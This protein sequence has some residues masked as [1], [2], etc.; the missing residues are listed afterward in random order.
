MR[1]LLRHRPRTVATIA[2][3]LTLLATPAAARAAA[4]SVTPGLPERGA[5]VTVAASGFEAHGRGIAQLAGARTRR[6]RV[7]ARGRATI[8]LYLRRATRTGS[9]RLRVRTSNKSVTTT[10]TVRA[11]RAAPSRLA[12]L[13]NGRRALLRPTSGRAGEPLELRITGHP[14]RAMLNVRLATT[15]LARRR[16]SSRGAL[17]VRAATPPVAP[18]AHRITI[19]SGRSTI[20]LPYRVRAS[21]PAPP[22]PPALPAPPPAPD[23][24]IAAAGDIACSPNDPDFAGGAGTSA[25]CRQR[26]TSDLLVGTGLSAVLALGD[27]QYDC[28]RPADFAGSFAPT[29]GRVQSIIRPTPGN[30]EYLS[31]NPDAY[32]ASGCTSGAQGY[33]S[34]FGAAAG[35]PARGYYS[36][37][38]GGWHI[39]SLNTNLA[40]ANSCPIVSCAAGSEQEQWLRADL[41]AHPASCTLAFFHHPLFTSK[42]RT[43]ASRP[44]WDALY[45][46]GVDVVLNGHVHNYERFAPQRP[47]GSADPA[48]G[49]RQFVVGTGGKSREDVGTAAPNSEARGNDFGVLELTL[50]R[51]SYDWRFLPVAGATFT[52]AGSTAC[53]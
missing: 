4:L 9:R 2:G 27:I 37:D 23:P 36:F 22:A 14:R 40:D 10:L 17:T 11:R 6:F 21:P 19:S 24:V 33:F 34:Y 7:D 43:Y 51:G 41:A 18:G 12:A 1:R 3:L 16:A 48:A 32:G 20:S 25:V 8:R 31:S 39:V 35:D 38:L 5:R 42:A 47:D 15:T 13:S 26:A 52:D 29:W 30:H 46:A 28:A 53:H 50:R 45:A 49:I 44:L